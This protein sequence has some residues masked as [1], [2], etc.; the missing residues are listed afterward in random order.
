MEPFE[1]ADAAS[2]AAAIDLLGDGARP[3][4]GGT[5]LL[6][7]MKVGIAAPTRLVNLKTIRGLDTIAEAGDGMRLGALVTL[8]AIAAHPLIRERYR[9]LSDA[10]GLA[11]SPQ[12]RN[13]GTLGGNLAQE[14]RCWYY[15]NPDFNCWLK[16]GETC[17]AREGENSHHAI[18]TDGSP[19]VSVYPSDP[20]T[21]L[22]ALGATVVV[23][24]ASGERRL[25]IGDYFTLP[26]DAN[27][28]R[29]NVLGPADLI[30]GVELPAPP[31]AG[32]YLKAMDRAAWSFALAGVALALTWRDGSSGSPHRVETAR[33]ALGGVAPVPRR[34][35][36]AE[37]YLSGKPLDAETA[38]EAGRLAVQG[39]APLAGNIYKLRL[40]SGLVERAL[41]TIGVV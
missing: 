23:Q 14:T 38:A 10:A 36:S 35:P 1:H 30:V 7:T 33:I 28:R 8:D 15:R 11:A 9:A 27:G 13:M 26:Q 16:G 2:V 21:A 25:P 40:V 34:V 22:L 19:C 29:L 3:I 18:F 37:S 12:L 6:T 24:S 17:F 41:L 4:A 39:A 20:A 31:S 32:L 5:D